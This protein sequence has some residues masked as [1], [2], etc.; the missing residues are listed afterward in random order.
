MEIDAH[1]VVKYFYPQSALSLQN[2][3]LQPS[4]NAGT[5]FV[6]WAGKA[7]CSR[8]L[9]AIV[10]HLPV[11]L[12]LGRPTS[13]QPPIL[14]ENIYIESAS[15]AVSHEMPAVSLCPDK[16]FSWRCPVSETTCIAYLACSG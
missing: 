7:K 11:N 14:R 13:V 6:D 8:L 9:I 4:G 1:L 10:L 3:E 5:I 15:D 16:F 2:S 12:S